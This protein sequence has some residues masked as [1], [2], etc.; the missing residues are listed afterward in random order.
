MKKG[1]AA[2]NKHTIK[3]N[4]E[5]YQRRRSLFVRN[6]NSLLNNCL[7][8][9]VIEVIVHSSG[10]SSYQHKGYLRASASIVG[11]VWP[12]SILRSCGVLNRRSNQFIHILLWLQEHNEDI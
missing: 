5:K 6:S 2:G 7:K 4:I 10:E 9:C 11:Y 8:S 12:T 3:I 1:C